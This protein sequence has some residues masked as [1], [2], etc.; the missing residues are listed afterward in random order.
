MV[1]KPPLTN[2]SIRNIISPPI[3][4]ILLRG[5]SSELNFLKKHIIEK[6]DEDIPNSPIYEILK[7]SLIWV[8]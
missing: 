4:A 2:T 8:P 3:N 5:E 6:R 1:K 7:K